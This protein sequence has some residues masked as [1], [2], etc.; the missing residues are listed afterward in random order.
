MDTLYK[1]V[2]LQLYPCICSL[3][4]VFKVQ[5]SGKKKKKSIL[6][7]VLVIQLLKWP[8]GLMQL[9]VNSNRP[10]PIP[11]HAGGRYARIMKVVFH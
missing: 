6:N 7:T 9:D 4:A 10:E 5:L 1:E 2:S 11:K 8:T 3:Q